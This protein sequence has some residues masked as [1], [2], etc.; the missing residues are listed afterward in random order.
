MPVIGNGNVSSLEEAQRMMRETGCDAVMIAR[1]AIRNPWIFSQFLS[2]DCSNPNNLT[3][4]TA[5]GEGVQGQGSDS[6]F[7][8]PSDPS[9]E[10]WPSMDQLKA[11]ESEYFK[12]AEESSSKQKFVDFHRRNFE[13][14][15][16]CVRTGNRSAPVGSPRTIHL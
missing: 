5:D 3:A 8:L 1:A 2:S 13:R 9:E 6:P 11:A 12:S 10:Y 14:L 4:V 16:S 7:S 15:R